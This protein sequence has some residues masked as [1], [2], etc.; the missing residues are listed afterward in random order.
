L[1][2]TYSGFQLSS[3]TEVHEYGD[4]TFLTISVV[5]SLNSR[6]LAASVKSREGVADRCRWVRIGP[7][8]GAHAGLRSLKQGSAISKVF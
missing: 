1:I 8:A 4:L 7:Y 6:G 5:V 2:F 3:P